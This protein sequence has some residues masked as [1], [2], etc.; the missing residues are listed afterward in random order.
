MKSFQRRTSCQG[1]NLNFVLDP[2]GDWCQV[3]GAQVFQQL[4]EIPIIFLEGLRIMGIKTLI[5]SR[6][7][8]TTK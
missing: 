8:Y 4:I 6:L 3:T 7:L 2:L 1:C 5:K